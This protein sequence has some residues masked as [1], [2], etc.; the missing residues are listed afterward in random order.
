MRMFMVLVLFLG[1][2]PVV[3]A[4]GYSAVSNPA[5]P[6]YFRGGWVLPPPG[7][8]WKCQRLPD[9]VDAFNFVRGEGSQHSWAASV[10]TM[11]LEAV[12]SH[13]DLSKLA[14]LRAEKG[15]GRPVTLRSFEATPDSTIAP[16]AVRYRYQIEDRKVPYDKGKLYVLE[17]R[18][19]LFVH[20]DAPRRLISVEFSQ[21]AAASIPLT[22]DAAADS[23]LARVA[24]ARIDRAAVR[25]VDVKSGP[26]LVRCGGVG[27]C[28]VSPW[29]HENG[30]KIGGEVLRLDPSS[31]EVQARAHIDGWIVDLAATSDAIWVCDR[32]NGVVLRL[33]PTSLAT[34]GTVKLGGH[35]DRLL[36]A[37]GALWVTDRSEGKIH[38]VDLSSLKPV[39]KP[40]RDLENPFTMLQVADLIWVVD[41]HTRK[42]VS[43]D[44]LK[45]APVG[46]PIAI[47][48]WAGAM[49]Y[50]DNSI[51]VFTGSDLAAVQRLD[52]VDRVVTATIPLGSDAVARGTDETQNMVFAGGAIWVGSYNDGRLVKVDPS[53]NRPGSESVG[54]VLGVTDMA[55]SER[56]VWVADQMLRAIALMPLP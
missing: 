14:R 26:Y 10:T 25:L 5:A 44:P 51:W 22:E 40:I 4:Q 49:A 28:V 11:D 24:L 16:L 50:G 48:E 54:A 21:R 43:V 36:V 30:K 7:S 2:T 47:A 17:A 12:S 13:E 15:Q 18:G 34:T 20:P 27:V 41:S 23:F 1:V 32:R 45:R 31:L 35:P 8:G 52:P 46:K 3:R 53:T 42:V 9:A 37:S 38:T 19:M 39:G 56:G 6:Y 33:D 29:P 55:A